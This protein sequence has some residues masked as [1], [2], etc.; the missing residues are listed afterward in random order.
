LA[1][2][3]KKIF[4]GNKGNFS[5]FGGKI[6]VSNYMFSLDKGNLVILFNKRGIFKNGQ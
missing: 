4:A 1:R 2:K 5:Y 3:K 6:S